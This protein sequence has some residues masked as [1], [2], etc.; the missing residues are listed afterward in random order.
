M[1]T[2]RP[3]GDKTHQN[4]NSGSKLLSAE[5]YAHATRCVN[6][7]AKIGNSTPADFIKKAFNDAE[8]VDR[9]ENLLK[10]ANV[11]LS[12]FNAL[13]KSSDVISKM[14]EAG[15]DIESISTQLFDLISLI[16]VEL[17]EEINTTEK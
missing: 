4:H 14:S 2:P 9:R 6:A 3:W 16:K 5:D 15:K 17:K 10:M 11:N 8:C 1:E 13:L 7:L 12:E